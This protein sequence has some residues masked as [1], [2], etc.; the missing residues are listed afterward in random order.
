MYKPVS[1]LPDHPAMSECFKTI[2]S[3]VVHFSYNKSNTDHSYLHHIVLHLAVHMK[4]I[5]HLFGILIYNVEEVC[6]FIK[7]VVKLVSLNST[8]KL[9]V[10]VFFF[11]AGGRGH[12]FYVATYIL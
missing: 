10:G 8:Q 2:P 3:P 5:L 1:N 9:F 12:L 7:E 11:W 6:R 4:I